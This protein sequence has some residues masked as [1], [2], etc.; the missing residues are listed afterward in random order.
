MLRINKIKEIMIVFLFLTKK[1]ARF[2]Y[3]ALKLMNKYNITSVYLDINSKK[4]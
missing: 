4:N 1:D 2:N 3:L